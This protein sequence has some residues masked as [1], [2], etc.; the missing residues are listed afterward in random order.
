[1]SR[2]GERLRNSQPVIA[3]GVTILGVSHSEWNRRPQDHRAL[4]LRCLCQFGGTSTPVSL[5]IPIRTS[6]VNQRDLAEAAAILA[7][8]ADLMIDSDHPLSS[9]LIEE[10]WV[11]CRRRWKS[12]NA[13][14]FSA[15]SFA[16]SAQLA[17]EV[18]VAEMPTRVWTAIYYVH[19]LNHRNPDGMRLVRQ[20]LQWHVEAR[21]STLQG[22]IDQY[23]RTELSGLLRL[24]R[25]RRRVERWT[26]FLIGT[27]TRHGVALN[28]AF[29]PDRCRN[30]AES[31]PDNPATDAVWP[32]T[33]AGLTRSFSTAPH[34]SEESAQSHTT[35]LQAQLAAFPAGAFH[36]DGRPL[37]A[38]LNR[39]V[40][41]LLDRVPHEVDGTR[42]EG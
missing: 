29:D 41:K 34:F 40:Q 25:V 18:M 28:V 30:N 5:R 7:R 24:D 6:L 9:S 35:V 15:E 1:M 27:I 33:I 8:H 37:S 2:C 20:A 17:E 21:Q 32:L 3:T 19:S 39:V 10:Y 42:S 31:M 12:W 23:H 26:D 4:D 38:P 16:D 13:R 14:E 11:A 36:N 22:M